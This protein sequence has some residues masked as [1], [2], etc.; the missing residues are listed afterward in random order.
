MLSRCG[1]PS[2]SV[3]SSTSPRIVR[4]TRS[5]KGVRLRSANRRLDYPGAL[6]GKD[7]VEGPRVLG[8]AVPDEEANVLQLLVYRE[9][10][11]FTPQE[12]I[13]PPG[14]SASPVPAWGGPWRAARAR[15]QSGAP[16]P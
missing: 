5:A 3:Q 4:T 15:S 7:L 13:R 14:R 2:T 12:H 11:S 8:I 16:G 6:A 9:V 1:R 10:C